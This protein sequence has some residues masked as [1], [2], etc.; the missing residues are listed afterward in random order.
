MAGSIHLSVGVL[1]QTDRA[2]RGDALQPRGDVHP[3]AHQIAVALLDDIA[4][5]NADP[6]DDAA[7]QRH[8]GVALES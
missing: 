4:E 6:K 8:A 5:V 3:I 2:R 1:G 7:L